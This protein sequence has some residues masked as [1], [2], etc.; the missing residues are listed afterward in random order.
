MKDDDTKI[1]IKWN[2]TTAMYQA[3]VD[4]K[5]KTSQFALPDAINDWDAKNKAE[6]IMAQYK[7]E[8]GDK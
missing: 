7:R 5:D 8:V 6:H 2:S 3:K 4:H 1:T